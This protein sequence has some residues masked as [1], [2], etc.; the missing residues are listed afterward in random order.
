MEIYN[1]CFS[2]SKENHAAMQNID[3]ENEKHILNFCSEKYFA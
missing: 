3:Q 1:S 2:I